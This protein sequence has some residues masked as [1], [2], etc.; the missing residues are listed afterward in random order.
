MLCPICQAEIKA[1]LA[2]CPKC[3]A[4]FSQHLPI[5]NKLAG[6]R[7]SIGEVLGEGGFGVTY[8][9]ADAL[10]KRL[11]AI[12]ELFP[13]GAIRAG[14]KVVPPRSLGT[15]GFT[16][17]K[18]SFRK[19]ANCLKQFNHEGI[20]RVFDVLEDNGTLYLIMEFLEGET[21]A[22]LIANQGKLSSETVLSLAYKMIAALQ[23]V[24]QGKLLHRDIKPE[25]IFLTKNDRAVLIDFGSARQFTLNKTSDHTRLVTPGY[26]PYEQYVSK[27][28]FG[29][30]TDI[31]ALGATLYHALSG[32]APP[33]AP[34]RALN[35][36]LVPL[37]DSVPDNLRQAVMASMAVRID[38]RPL[39]SSALI[40]LLKGSN[41]STYSSTATKSSKV[42]SKNTATLKASAKKDSPKELHTLKGHNDC[43]NSITFNASGDLLVSG[44]ADKTIKLWQVSSGKC[45]RTLTRRNGWV[46]SVAVSPNSEMLASKSFG[47]TIKLWQLSNAKR[48]KTLSGHNDW[49]Y[50]IAFSPDSNSLISGSGDYTIK[51]WQVDNGKSLN[52]FLGHTHSV[53]SVAFSP[54]GDIIASGSGDNTVK[55]WQIST[56]S[57]LT[58]LVGHSDY[59]FSVTFSPK[60]DLLASASMDGTIK[61][62]GTK[63]GS[64]LRTLLGHDSWVWSVTFSPSGTLLASGSEDNTVKL[65]RVRDGK[66]LSTISEHNKF[67][68]SVAFNPEGKILAS[69]SG[70]KTIKLWQIE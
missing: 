24:H 3:S 36:N 1:N 25:N 18:V 6:G 33:D 54:C 47:N 35:D 8:K 22:Q 7:Y 31:Y 55:L 43:V 56:G 67:V 62:W 10:L 12:K 38:A 4:T 65:W 42:A 17:S 19:E 41:E 60:G 59:V 2:S 53:F 70:D 29:P 49:V 46:F 16:E 63:N 9:G 15:Q 64:L 13:E 51:L 14:K 11:V 37:P 45:L 68:Y 34:S 57:L 52:T 44:S 61:L 21:L 23:K 66:N 28:K 48:L 27:A 58:T 30:Y 32:Q 40:N 50:S 26:A 39:N 69:G 5:G 20:V